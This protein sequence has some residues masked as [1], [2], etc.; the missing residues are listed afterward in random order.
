MIASDAGGARKNRMNEKQ[1][2]ENLGLGPV[3]PYSSI[4]ASADDAVMMHIFN[5]VEKYPQ[6]SEKKI[7]FYTGIA[8]GLAHSFM[9][10]V[11]AKGW[12]KVRKVGARR[13]LYYMTA[14]GFAEKGRLTVK[15]LGNTLRTYKV[16]QKVIEEYLELCQRNGWEMLVV[17]GGNELA[18]IAV[19]NITGKGLTLV[20][21]LINGGEAGASAKK[22]GVFPFPEIENM[23]FDRILVCEHGFAEWAAKNNNQSVIGKQADILGKVMENSF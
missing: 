21:R 23:E 7:T 4:K 9:R 19:L 13:W 3:S 2:K 22:D 8:A 17:A 20:G 16:A 14:E 11:A 15:Y 1:K 6:I 18:D 12:I 10:K 5:L